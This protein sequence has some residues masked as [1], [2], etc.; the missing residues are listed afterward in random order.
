MAKFKSC[1]WCEKYVVPFVKGPL[2]DPSCK[3]YAAKRKLPEEPKEVRVGKFR[4]RL[5]H[6]TS[7]MKCR[8][9]LF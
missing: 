5:D 9:K 3:L 7:V 2:H 4:R 8:R 1:M 6:H